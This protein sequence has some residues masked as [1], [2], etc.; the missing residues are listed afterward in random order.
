MRI[1]GQDNN[2]HIEGEGA[3]NAKLAFARIV[4]DRLEYEIGH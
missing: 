3:D 2:W 4:G 1:V